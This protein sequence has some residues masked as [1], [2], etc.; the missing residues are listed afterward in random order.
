MVGEEELT[1]DSDLYTVKEMAVKQSEDQF[2]F[3]ESTLALYEAANNL[4]QFSV[5]CR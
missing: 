1:G 4:T 2:S 3:V 5:S